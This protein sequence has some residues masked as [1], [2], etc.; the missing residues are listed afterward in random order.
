MKNSLIILSPKE[1]GIKIRENGMKFETLIFI[2]LEY[3][4]S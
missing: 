3:V 4:S 2:R 1:R